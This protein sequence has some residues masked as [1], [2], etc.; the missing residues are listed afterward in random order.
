MTTTLES[1]LDRHI[2]ST[3]KIVR[4]VDLALSLLIVIS[5]IIGGLFLAILADHWLLKG[6][7]TMPLRFGIFA[8]LAAI[9][10]LYI[11]KKIV[12][13]FLYPINPVYTADLIEQDVP[14]LKN[15][16]RMLQSTKNVLQ[17]FYKSLTHRTIMN[18]IISF[19]VC[20]SFLLVNTLRAQEI[21]FIEL[22]G[23]TKWVS[24][25][26]FSPDGK[27][28]LTLS[29]DNTVR[30]WDTESGKELVKWGKGNDDCGTFSPDAKKV[31]MTGT[32]SSIHIR[33]VESGNLLQTLIENNS[34]RII[35]IAFLS[36][37]KEIVARCSN[38]PD[39]GVHTFDA[40]SGKLLKRLPLETGIVGFSQDGKRSVVWDTKDRDTVLIK[41]VESGKVLRTLKGFEGNDE[42]QVHFS[43][44]GKRV[45]IQAENGVTYEN[46]GEGVMNRWSGT[47]DTRIVD[48]DSGKEWTPK[49]SGSWHWDCPI[50]FSPDG[51]KIV[52]SNEF[53]IA[54]I[55][56]YGT[57]EELQKLVGHVSAVTKVAF[58]PDGKKIVT[59]S[60]DTYGQDTTVRIWE[61]IGRAHV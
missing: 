51:K 12:P 4:R 59:R 27:K 33:D 16:D 20:L 41:D 3:S 37:G 1:T 40:E 9:A 46:E 8:A 42:M 29:R 48:V 47:G 5:L 38:I 50:A 10:G 25:A 6:G 15:N 56:D 36:D 28:L 58:F 2:G 18:K 39:W 35:D 52:T 23:H 61:E 13:I 31:V 45:V 32:Y 14:T 53:N 22:K 30:I 21:P 24:S 44:D 19:A 55:W 17:S 11:Y 34:D 57:G 60:Y 49:P 26:V 54:R 7:L 43:P